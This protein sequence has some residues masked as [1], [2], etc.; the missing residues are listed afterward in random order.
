MVWKIRSI[1]K[2]M[3]KKKG[4]HH[5]HLNKM[6]EVLTEM[7]NDRCW[8]CSGLGHTSGQCPTLKKVKNFCRGNGSRSRINSG[9]IRWVRAEYKKPPD[10]P[11]EGEEDIDMAVVDSDSGA[12]SDEC[13][14]QHSKFS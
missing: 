1:I 9:L 8:S 10:P 7:K 12:N 11:A 3:A 5:Y 2:K 14:G 13:D 4:G 6:E